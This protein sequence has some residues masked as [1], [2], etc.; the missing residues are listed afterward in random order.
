[1]TAKMYYDNDADPVGP[2]GADGRDHRLREP[3]ACPCPEPPRVGGRR[4]RRA[5]ADEPEPDAG[6]GRRAAG[7][8]G[9]RGGRGGRRRDDPRPGY[10]PE[11]RLRRR[12]RAEPAT[13]PAADVRPRLQLP[14]QADRPAGRRRRRDGRPEGARATSSG[15][16]TRPAAACPRCSPSS[17]T[18]A[19]PARARVLAYARA[20]G[21]TRAGVLETTFAEETET[22][23]FGE[24]SVLCGGHGGARQD[25][26]RD[27]RRGGLPARARLLRDDARAQA[28]RRPDVP[29][30]PQLHALQRQ[31]H[32]RV[33]RLRQRPADHRRPRPGDDEA[34]PRRDPGRLVRGPL[35][36]RE[37]GRPAGVRA[38]PPAGPRPP[39]RAG[40]RRSSGA[41]WRSS[42][43]SS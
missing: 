17:A 40:R 21:C 8:D 13:R 29:R 42:T 26:L 12:D 16:S 22:D 5:R 20:L 10:R 6:R 41:R 19:A 25:G 7:P 15:A 3:G 30:R 4:G 2:G 24:Q 28:D 32:G 33:R 1:M 9:A 18:R 14:L 38:A 43:R 23:L 11:G 36:R 34:G 39:H 37:R 35:D 27:A 31:R